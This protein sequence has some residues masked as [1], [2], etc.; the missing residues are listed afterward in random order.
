MEASNKSNDQ[1]DY[2]KWKCCSNKWDTINHYHHEEGVGTLF[3]WKLCLYFLWNIMN[4]SSICVY[5]K[6]SLMHSDLHISSPPIPTEEEKHLLRFSTGRFSHQP[7]GK[8]ILRLP[9]PRILEPL[10]WCPSEGNVLHQMNEKCFIWF[11]KINSSLPY[12]AGWAVPAW[13]APSSW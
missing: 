2:S 6:P 1:H 10:R 3:F 12:F 7:F 11:G 4:V 9:P 5:T 13:A 8:F